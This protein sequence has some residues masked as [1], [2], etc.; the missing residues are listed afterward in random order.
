MCLKSF[1]PPEDCRGERIHAKPTVRR[2]APP[3]P[4]DDHLGGTPLR[5]AVFDAGLNRVEQANR[6]ERAEYRCFLMAEKALMSVRRP[7]GGRAPRGRRRDS[8]AAAS[9]AALTAGRPV[10][11]GSTGLARVEI[12]AAPS[13]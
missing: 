4:H 12:A 11:R 2:G 3:R 7:R 1:C 8:V 6:A 13:S 10:A 9:P 5:R